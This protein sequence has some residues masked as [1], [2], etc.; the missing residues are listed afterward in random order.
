MTKTTRMSF[1]EM[2]VA[3]S[4]IGRNLKQFTEAELEAR[5]ISYEVLMESV[6]GPADVYDVLQGSAAAKWFY[7]IPAQTFSWDE[8]RPIL[9]RYVRGKRGRTVSERELCRYWPTFARAIE[10]YVHARR[11]FELPFSHERSIRTAQ[12][13]RQLIQ[14]IVEQ[15]SQLYGSLYAFE[16]AS[17]GPSGLDPSGDNLRRALNHWFFELSGVVD[18]AISHHEETGYEPIY[19]GMDRFMSALATIEEKSTAILEEKFDAKLLKRVGM[20]SDPSLSVLVI[21]SAA[22]WTEI[23]GRPAS[24]GKVENGSDNNS[25][26]FVK[27][28]QSFVR[29]AG[30]SNNPSN[31]TIATCLRDGPRL[32][33]APRPKGVQF[34]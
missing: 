23:T 28:I 25:P 19:F 22:I 24:A 30:F 1:S 16:S 4:K 17:R 27:L 13:A 11:S 3:R 15:A 12:D 21:D 18:E 26:D 5:R 34:K 8:M 6:S 31:S 9:T 10:N 2:M 29:L 32:T 33:H 7:S 20:R 14:D